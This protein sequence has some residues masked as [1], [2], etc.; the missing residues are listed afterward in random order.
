MSHL[1]AFHNNCT[2]NSIHID[3]FVRIYLIT[4][5]EYILE[6]LTTLGRIHIVN[7]SNGFVNTWL[8][9]QI[10]VSN[11]IAVAVMRL[12]LDLIFYT[13]LLLLLIH[14]ILQIL[15]FQWV[16]LWLWECM[17]SVNFVVSKVQS[18]VKMKW[19]V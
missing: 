14:C 19:A 11:F 2:K 18:H 5:I 4:N 6:D 10:N 17:Y 16:L 8:I 15:S 1:N 7:C 13:V 12:L 9:W 3:I